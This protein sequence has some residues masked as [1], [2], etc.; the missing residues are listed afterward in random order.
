MI[1]AI[2]KIG[3]FEIETLKKQGKNE[4]DLFIDRPFTLREEIKQEVIVLN[5]EIKD[6]IIIIKEIEV[7]PYPFDKEWRYLYKQGSPNGNDFSLTTR[8]NGNFDKFFKRFIRNIST[9]S[10]K[11]PK[12]LTANIEKNLK[13]YSLKDNVIVT[14]KIN[15]KYLGENKNFVDEFYKKLFDSFSIVDGKSSRGKGVSYIE[16]NQENVFGGG[17]PFSFF[18][19]DKPG[20]AYELVKT[21]AVKM[22]PLSIQ[23]AK[24]LIAGKN[25][26]SARFTHTFAGQR[27]YLIPT[28]YLSENIEII[29]IFERLSQIQSIKSEKD[30]VTDKENEI[31]VE[32][33]K[34]EDY[35]SYN[36]LFFKEDNSAFRI[37]KLIE[38]VLPS[39]IRVILES[40]DEIN[41]LLHVK[42]NL[43]NKYWHIV[44]FEQKILYSL[45]SDNSSN[46]KFFE[47]LDVVFKGNEINKNFLIRTF[48]H[49]MRDAIHAT[50]MKKG[51][52]RQSIE[53]FIIYIL[54]ERLNLLKTAKPTVHKHQYGGII[55]DNKYTKSFENV[56]QS[57]GNIFT[58][59]EIK[60]LFSL[61]FLMSRVASKQKKSL[62]SSPI[63]NKL[64]GLKLR[65]KDIVSPK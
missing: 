65:K 63:L 23:N 22:L 13:D 7:E 31:L 12:E 30:D 64:K 62:G 17:L 56:F 37:L 21:N 34:Q 61:G 25:T 8:Y 40:I 6:K 46:E 20:F 38:D 15:G 35:V 55:M 16:N 36:L 45:F 53:C 49:K 10:L 41:K 57:Y 48:L 52:Y 9:F 60:Y 33:S 44:R 32:L 19:T 2:A 5:I 29:Q 58:N 42:Y 54:F 59:P 14:V 50:G 51:M 28:F 11:L 18:T 47:I 27:F 39:R 4:L 26:L 43:T 24:N 1:N 3:E